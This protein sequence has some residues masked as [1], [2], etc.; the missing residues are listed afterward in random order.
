MQKH[1]AQIEIYTTMLCPYCTM[2]KRLLKTKQVAFV[3]IDVTTD[4]TL[5]EDMTRR[6][7][8]RRTVPQIFINDLPVG[9][10]DDLL[11]LDK[12][13]GLDKLLSGVSSLA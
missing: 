13:G 5:R 10:F 11:A 7:E 12:S 3:E 4:A 6:A 8:G 9:G 2:A 1:A